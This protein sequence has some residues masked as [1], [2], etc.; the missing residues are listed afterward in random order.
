MREWCSIEQIF[1]E[2]ASYIFRSSRMEK[3]RV[4]ERERAAE[5]KQSLKSHQIDKTNKGRNEQTYI[6]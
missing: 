2:I 5:H 4:K 3:E 6:L 1:L